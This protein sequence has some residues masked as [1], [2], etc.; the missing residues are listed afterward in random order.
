MPSSKPA[1]ARSPRPPRRKAAVVADSGGLP[2]AKE[3]AADRGAL[4]IFLRQT[5]DFRLAFALHND[6]A[7]R[8]AYL[9]DLAAELTQD[10]ITLIT[11]DLITESKEHTL[12]GRVEEIVRQAPPGQRIVVMV[13]NLE[14]KADYTPELATPGAP[15]NTWISNA[16][17]HRDLFPAACP[18]PLVIWMTELLE[19]A[20]AFQAP[21][22]TRWRSHLFDLRTRAKPGPS[23]IENEGRRLASNDFRL[24]PDHRLKRLEEEL[25][26]YRKIGDRQAEMRTLNSIGL[27]RFDLGDTRLAKLDF[28]AGLIIAREIGDRRAESGI[29]GNLGNAH[30]AVGDTQKAV[31]CY[32]Q[33]L[34]IDRQIGNRRGESNAL[35]CLGIIQWNLGDDRKAIKYY[36]QQL[37]IAREIGNRRG[38]GMALGNLGIA[39]ATLGKQ[40]EAIEFYRQYL[41]IAREIGDR[42]GEGNAL[43]N[44][45]VA[46][47]ALGDELK[48]IE[49]YERYLAV[50]RDVSDRRGEGNAL[51]NAALSFEKLGDLAEA[52]SR[53]RAALAIYEA[54]EDVSASKV[55]A[56]LARWL[57]QG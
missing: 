35:G 16:N 25:T 13:I 23:P 8:D 30:A 18:A 15:T 46:H 54:V 26:A 34:D 42:R 4:G 1:V 45:G 21:D 22:L 50:A 5:H 9:R 39:H 29:L 10:G 48:A 55:R 14:A 19:R 41:A 6:P 36:T 40:Q 31:A 38:E 17:F 3:V 28:E 49:F 37:S 51:W 20:L 44:L 27:A 11:V 7:G 32:E 57:A 47:D 53:A 33:Q 12:L 24:H 56:T 52:I 2:T 43:G